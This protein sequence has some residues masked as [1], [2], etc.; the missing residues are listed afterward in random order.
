M[1][2]VTP[3]RSSS[4]FSKAGVLYFFTAND[5]LGDA[6]GRRLR[7]T[8]AG[9]SDGMDAADWRLGARVMGFAFKH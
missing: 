9:Q 7:R 1:Y 2:W 3:T 4:F 8:R 6:P 5:T